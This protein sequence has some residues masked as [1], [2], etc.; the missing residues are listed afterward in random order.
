MNLRDT[1]LLLSLG[2]L[3]GL[4]PGRALAQ[5]PNDHCQDVVPGA[6]AIGASITF[7]GN[8]EGATLDGDNVAGSGLDDFQS[9]VVWEAFTTTACANVRIAFCGSVAAFGAD[10][11]WNVLTQQCPADQL[12]ITWDYNNNECPDGQPVLYFNDLPAGT[13]YYPVWADANGPFGDYTMTVSA[14]AC[15]AA[16]GVADA[17]P[18]QQLC[19]PAT[20]A[21]MAAHEPLA[22]ATGTWTVV[23]GSFTIADIHDP[24]TEFTALAVGEN[25]A[26]WTVDDGGGNTTSDQVRIVV[27]DANSLAADAGMDQEIFW[28][29]SSTALAGNAPVF[30]ATGLWTVVSGAG[31]FADPANPHTAVSGLATGLNVF[32]WTLDNGPCDN[33]VTMDEVEISVH[34]NGIQ[35]PDLPVGASLTF[36]GNNTGATDDF[37]LGFASAWEAFNLVTCANVALDYCSTDASFTAFAMGLYTGT[38][39][40][41]HVQADSSATCD[42]GAPIQYFANLAPGTYWVP[43][44]MD[45]DLALGDYVVTATAS[46]CQ[47]EAPANNQC[48][49]AQLVAV[50]APDACASGSVAGD[51]TLADGSGDMPAC[52]DG[53]TPWQDLWYSF[54]SAEGQVLS[55]TLTPGTISNAGLE[56]FTSCDGASVAC[57]IDGTPIELSGYPA[58]TFLVR[59]FSMGENAGGTFDLCITGDGI[60]G[61]AHRTA[62][63]LAVYPNPGTGNFRFVAG[64]TAPDAAIA[65][66]DMA[67]RTVYASRTALVAGQ[68]QPLALEG[69]L[70]PGAYLLEVVAPEGRSTARL[71]VQ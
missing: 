41:A 52:G 34:D 33:G 65:V 43:V 21:T 67:G 7:T 1:A 6:L 3:L 47:P 60:T 25:I 16:T 11:Y 70:K 17:G 23:A 14:T 8:N 24:N 57:E 40:G 61:M 2:T 36:D 63:S 64:F 50:V 5:P 4:A 48:A 51:N 12:V 38:P 10:Y 30:P 15:G 69:A 13:Y 55:I 68:S 45:P 71:L 18:D 37:G 59:V 20:A 35:V 28:P 62:A 53:G 29:V 26:L 27:Y 66:R 58:S 49:D 46:A 56:V 19:T 32:R 22:P 9:A 31:T 39:G 42:N 44:L 54:Q